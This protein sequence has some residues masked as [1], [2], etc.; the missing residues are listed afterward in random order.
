MRQ[1]STCKKRAQHT[2]VNVRPSILLR[3]H[4]IVALIGLDTTASFPRQLQALCHTAHRPVRPGCV[5]LY[6]IYKSYQAVRVL[7]SKS[8][9]QEHSQLIHVAVAAAAVAPAAVAAL[10]AKHPGPTPMWCL[11]CCQAHSRPHG[12]PESESCASAAPAAQ[13]QTFRAAAAAAAAAADALHMEQHHLPP[14]Q[15]LAVALVVEQH[16]VGWMMLAVVMLSCWVRAAAPA[17]AGGGGPTP[18][19]VPATLDCSVQ[20]APGLKRGRQGVGMRL[21]HRQLAAAQAVPAPAAWSPGQ[22]EHGPVAAAGCLQ[23]RCCSRCC[24]HCC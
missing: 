12:P 4:Q 24:P 1:S 23:W 20:E 3:A 14:Q 10:P 7:E 15:V 6:Y 13:Q 2:H 17:A 22:A 19:A 18:P 16:T 21:D 11:C 5:H 9:L 8:S